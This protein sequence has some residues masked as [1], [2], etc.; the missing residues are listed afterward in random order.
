MASNVVFPPDEKV[1]LI[2]PLTLPQV[3]GAALAIAGF[4]AGAMLDD[5][6]RWSVGAVIVLAV[7]FALWN[8]KPLRLVVLQQ[9][10]WVL[11]RDKEWSAPL[12]GGSGQ[13]PCFRNI[14]YHMV[15]SD[16]GD[17]VGV[18]EARGGLFSVVFEVDSSSTVLLSSFEQDARFDAWGEV[19]A[20]LCVERGTV[21]TAERLAW[22][23]IH[24]A[25][26]PAALVRQHHRNGVD[27]PASADYADYVSTFGSV[28][29]AHRVLIT[30]TISR[31]G[32]Y[33]LA[34]QQGFAGRPVDV[35]KQ[36][37]VDV[38]RDL[39]EELTR[40]GFRCGPLLSPAEIARAVLDAIDPFAMRPDGPSARERFGLPTRTGPEQVSVERH[41]VAI[42]GA[43]HRVFALRWPRTVVDAAWMH[44]PLQVDGPKIM[45][46]VYAGVP[47]SVAD[48]RREALTNRSESNNQ[49]TAGRKGR[50]RTKD[51]QKSAA[52]L[53]A[54]EA[55]AGGHQELDAYSLVVVSGRSVEELNQRSA[56]LRQAMRQAGRGEVREM[57]AHHD[58]ALVAALPL[59]IWVKETVE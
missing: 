32:R 16:C 20:G 7:T 38:G 36:A 19:L 50:V 41:M 23:D 5:V 59:G 39:A 3:V 54:E 29:A 47:P 25:S 42:D 10:G 52:L 27:G 30:A 33:R 26:D 35:M 49:V 17:P 6:I 22:T 40:Q 55:V 43:C 4:V 56:R 13:A 53:A 44:L 8:G 18:V 37:A 31:G 14:T 51:K 58:H 48:V 1:G 57:T 28:A 9:L 34:K 11:R 12:R 46:T 24:Q 15:A 2:G 45:T 21:L